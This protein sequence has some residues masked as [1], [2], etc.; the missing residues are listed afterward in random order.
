MFES[1]NPARLPSRNASVRKLPF[2]AATFLLIPGSCGQPVSGATNSRHRR[3]HSERMG[4]VESSG[5]RA[6]ENAC[7]KQNPPKAEPRITRLIYC[8]SREIPVS[9][10]EFPTEPHFL[11]SLAENPS[12]RNFCRNSA[13]CCLENGLDTLSFLEV[14]ARRALLLLAGMVGACNFLTEWEV[15]RVCAC[16]ITEKYHRPL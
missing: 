11:Q 5:R 1:E 9:F 13:L 14:S 12:S 15:L 4:A 8:E 10:R 3:L 6:T 7:G 16:H 2:T